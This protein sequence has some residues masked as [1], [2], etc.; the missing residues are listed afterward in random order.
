MIDGSRMEL[1]KAQDRTMIKAAV[2]GL[3][4][5]GQTILRH[6]SDSTII[7]PVLC[8][9]PLE[10][11]RAAAS[12]FG[13]E[14][15]PHF[16]DALAHPDVQAVILCTPQERHAEQIAAAARSGRH[17][18]CEKPLCTTSADAELAIAAVRRAG[19][20]LGIGHERRFEPAV[21]EMRQRFAAGEF[22]NPLML[23]GNFSQDK[24]LKLPGDN[25]RLSNTVN[26]VGPLSATGIHMVDLSIALL[27]RPTSVWARLARL[28]SDFA[29]GDTLSLTIGFATGA[30]A[31]LGAVLA[32]PFMG[33][34]AL[35]GSNGWME[36]RDRS[37][38]ENST[39][40]DVTT[41]HRD[42]IPV[43][44]FYAPHPAVR[45][46]LEAFGRAALGEASYPVALDE[47]LMNV[48]SFEAI[49]RSVKSGTIEAIECG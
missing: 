13:V 11:A 46:N 2:I 27:G 35:L 25:W 43:T 48:R 6:L 14:T 26:P 47:M 31:L 4:W 10:S 30:T 16:D 33:R 42:E 5:W 19:V 29:N 23:E 40:W 12:A 8:V 41:V 44:A 3:G 34:L 24:F 18:F 37:H 45:D 49:H 21:I 17:V 36:V 20:Q 7:S 39:G 32:T 38:P 15:S 9:D 1:A 28:G 22:G